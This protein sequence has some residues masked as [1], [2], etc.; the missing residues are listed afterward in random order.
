[1]QSGQDEQPPTALDQYILRGSDAGNLYLLMSSFLRDGPFDSVG[2][3]CFNTE[4]S[5][6]AFSVRLSPGYFFIGTRTARYLSQHPVAFA[7]AEVNRFITE[8][9]QIK[10]LSE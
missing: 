9:K 4:I 8:N 1:M 3:S 2:R 10:M 5:G 7:E 6:G